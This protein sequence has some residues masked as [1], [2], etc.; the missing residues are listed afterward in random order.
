[1]GF[2][3]WITSKFGTNQVP[4]SG[5]MFADIEDFMGEIYI[6]EVAFW[7]T[8]TIIANAI[9]KC[10]FKT[11]YE[12]KEKKGE[13]YYL[14]NVEPNVNQSSAQFI[15]Q[16]IT[17]LYRDNE[18]LVIENNGQLFVAD[19]Y[20]IKPYALYED[21]FTDVTVKDFHF[22]RQF[23][24]S[25]VLYFKLSEKKMKQVIDALFS[26]YAK[27]ITHTMK[28][29]QRSRGV[30]GIFGYDTL[31]T[32]PA[33]K[34]AFDSLIGDKFKKYMESANAILPLGKGQSYTETGSKTYASE[35]TRD[36]R[37]MIDDISD[38]TAKSFG[39][40]PALVRGDVQ[41]IKEAMDQFLTFCIDPLCDLLQEEINR[42]RV[43]KKDYL[44]G[45]KTIINT[46]CIKHVDILDVTAAIE[47]LVSSGCFTINDVRKTLG[48]EPIDEDWANQ[49]FMTKNFAT[50]EELLQGIGGGKK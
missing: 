48:L 39:V 10:E 19:S 47:K 30:K 11:I 46:E 23:K 15:H 43:G 25:E 49:Y 3:N 12:G 41:G 38:F 50:V 5:D 37:A 27:L 22:N 36:I 16:L 21:V 42:K 17:Q 4:M 40:P 35:S 32:A 9:S 26:S 8:I 6:R 34:E 29:Y 13:E 18:C 7:G 33:E 24:Q 2:I 44:K 28:A 45:T 14:W 1:V 20:N 31:P